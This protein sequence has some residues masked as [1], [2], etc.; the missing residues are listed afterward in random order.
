MTTPR[1]EE[2]LEKMAQQEWLLIGDVPTAQSWLRTALTEARQAGKK[3]GI[4]E[5]VE[6]MEEMKRTKV[7]KLFQHHSTDSI[8]TI[9]IPANYESAFRLGEKIALDDTIK[10]LQDNK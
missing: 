10:A 1:I 6:V 7:Y 3:A 5:A 4:D 2:L 8:E 9:T